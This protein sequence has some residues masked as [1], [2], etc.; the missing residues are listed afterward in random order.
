MSAAAFAWH[1]THWQRLAT[2]TARPHHALLLCGPAGQGKRVF[3]EALAARL[4][5]D[6][7]EPQ[8]GLACGSCVPCQWRVA[9]THPDLFRIVP[10]GAEDADEGADAPAKARAA[11]QIVIAQIRALQAALAVTGHHS[12]RRV[13]I[14]DPAEAM[15]PVT[16]NAL[17]KLL[18]EPPAGVSFLLVSAQ[19]MRLLPTMRSRCQRWD[20]VPP[21]PAEVESWLAGQGLPGARE[22]LDLTGG[23]PLAAAALAEAGGVALR[24]RFT[25]DMSSL[26]PAGALR[27]AAQWE[28][29]LKSKEAAAAGFDLVMLLDWALRWVTDLAQARLNG[30]VRYF[31]DL[32]RQLAQAGAGASVAGVLACYNDFLQIRRHARHPLNLRLV[33]EDMLLR[34]CRHV[35]GATQ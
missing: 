5:C 24:K 30:R 10:E 28:A 26:E 35:H 11:T 2:S 8:S 9:G 27:L 14:V 13:V 1:A 7:P 25:A 20:F 6:A 12:A 34:Y 33:L 15:N 29:W 3:A 21:S 32:A 16:A 23:T 18:E 17:L 4:L 22:L 31:P 19:P